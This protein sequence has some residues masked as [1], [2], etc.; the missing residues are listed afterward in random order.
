M[1]ARPTMVRGL[2]Y[3]KEKK[4]FCD[5]PVYRKIDKKNPAKL[6]DGRKEFN[7]VVPEE[8][9]KVEEELVQNEYKKEVVEHLINMNQS[10]NSVEVPKDVEIQIA[11]KKV[12]RV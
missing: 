10:N 2:R 1:F 5:C 4:S 12:V 11:K 6:V 9:I 7:Y 8:E 3:A